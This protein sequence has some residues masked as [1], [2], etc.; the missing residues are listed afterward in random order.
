[1]SF[2]FP[3]KKLT[4]RSQSKPDAADEQ[5]IKFSTKDISALE[6]EVAKLR[7]KASGISDAIKELQNKILE[8]GGVKLRAIQSKVSTTKGLL[9]LAN[10]AIT[11]A[12]VG[13]IKAQRDM[14][15]LAKSL[16]SNKAK[17]EEAES[18]LAAVQSE[19]QSCLQNVKEV[20][21]KVDEASQASEYA[22]EELAETKA[23][24][25]EK[26]GAIQSWRKKEMELKQQIEDNGRVVKDCK[27]RLRGWGKRHDELELAFV[28]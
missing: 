19:L 15:K 25:D 22:K 26:S 21:D 10:E 4:S 14:D 8:V 24:L 7:S 16:E 17:L 11:K 9:D 2:E 6:G 18:E 12:E 27:D 5:R 13:Q 3:V 28:E 23:E 20:K 1:M